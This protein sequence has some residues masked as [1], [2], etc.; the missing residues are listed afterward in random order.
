MQA[1]QDVIIKGKPDARFRS[2]LEAEVD[3]ACSRLFISS[4]Y[5]SCIALAIFEI[6]NVDF[7]RQ[8]FQLIP[9]ELSFASKSSNNRMVF[10][11]TVDSYE[12]PSVL[13]STTDGSLR[14]S[15]DLIDSICDAVIIDNSNHTISF[16]F[17]ILSFTNSNSIMRSKLLRNYYQLD[18]ISEEIIK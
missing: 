14:M 7:L 8:L 3:K 10:T 6:S 12:C 16:V 17:D 2:M 13:D 1:I 5:Y 18:I 9:T 15:M 11:L 4:S